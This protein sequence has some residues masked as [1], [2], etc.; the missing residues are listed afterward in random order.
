ML[1]ELKM[2]RALQMRVNRRTER[3]SKLIVGEQAEKADLI[4]ALQRPGRNS[5]GNLPNHPGPG[6]GEEPMKRTIIRP[7][8]AIAGDR[9]RWPRMAGECGRASTLPACPAAGIVL[10][11]AP[12]LEAA[13]RG[14]SQ[15]QALAWL[16]TTKPDAAVAGE[17]RRALGRAFPEQPSGDELLDCLARDDRPGRRP[18]R[19]AGGTL[20]EAAQLADRCP[21]KPG[22]TTRSCRRWSAATCAS[23]RPLAGAG[24]VVRRGLEQLAGLQSRRRG[25]PGRVALLP[26][27]GL[28][29]AA[30]PG[31]RAQGIDE[32][33]DGAEA[34]PRRYVAV[35][36]LMQADLEDAEAR[37]ARPHRPADGGHLAAAGPG[38]GGPK[39]R[40]V[41]DGVIESLDKIIE[42]IEDEQ[43]QQQQQH[44]S[45]NGGQHSKP[46]NA[47][48]PM[49]GKG[50]GEVTKRNI[51][52]K[53]GWGDLPPKE[54]EEAMQQIGR[55]FPSHYRDVIEQ[56]FRRLA[57]EEE[58]TSKA[59]DD[60]RTL[61]ASCWPSCRWRPRRSSRCSR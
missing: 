13:G 40:K 34:S 51:G 39:V 26:G 60:A 57:A 47:S 44:S 55:D 58:N 24:V 46:A 18:R 22:C 3:Y 56:Y 2:I 1:A 30:Q 4:D 54:R 25:G 59:S 49:G 53:S 23:L 9:F 10:G 42:K 27:R 8:V 45:G 19:Q 33:L 48:R 7:G 38:P 28:S 32:L 15:T 29:S 61:L 31:R 50:P 52:N 11:K 35:A 14:G 41:E 5:S 16:E 12:D 21:T 43:Q 6:N 36:R 37:H 20:L 17:G